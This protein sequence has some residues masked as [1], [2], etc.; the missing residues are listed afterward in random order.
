MREHKLLILEKNITHLVS[1]SDVVYIVFR[2]RKLKIITDDREYTGI[3]TLKQIE[4]ELPENSFVR[5]N[6]SSLISLSRIAHVNFEKSFIIMDNGY[7]VSL[8]VRK[9]STLKNVLYQ[10]YSKI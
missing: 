7:K 1:L 10:M 8:S 5:V 3:K 6:H 2:N 4:E 9:R